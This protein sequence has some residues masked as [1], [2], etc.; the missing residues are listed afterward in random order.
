MKNDLIPQIFHDIENV[1]RNLEE[2]L[3]LE[4]LLN[5]EKEMEVSCEDTAK[6]ALSMA[7]QTRKIEQTIEKSRSE[8]VKPHLDY[9]RAVNKIVKD[10]ASKLSEMEQ[11][12]TKKINTWIESQKDNP[13]TSVEEL[14]VDDGMLYTQKGWTFII[15]NNSL[16]PEEYKIPEP[17]LIQ[18][19]VK[20]GVRNI[21]GVKIY[22]I[23]KTLIRIKN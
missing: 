8:I 7:L 18:D 9:Q 17:M 4:L 13:F 2:T 16:V 23:E 14:R 3:N 5:S 1:K 19:A 20:N 21:P 10:L 11:S 22:E 6:H 12:L 15:E